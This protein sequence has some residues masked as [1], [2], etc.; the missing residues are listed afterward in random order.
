MK[1]NTATVTVPLLVLC[2]G[3]GLW[4]VS[5]P[6]DVPFERHL[7]DEGANEACA[8]ADVNGDKRSD[9][10][11]GENW[12]E[13]PSWTKHHFRDLPY[14]NN[15]I[16]D[17]SDLPLDVNNDGRIDIVSV[18][19]FSKKI[20]W[21]ENPG[22]G[23]AAW[24]EHAVETDSPVEFAFLVDLDNDGKAREV[25]PQFGDEKKPLAWYEARD[26]AFVKHVV[27]PKSYGHGIGAGDVNKDGR[28]DI[29]TPE[30]WLEAPAD[31]RSG[32]WKMHSGF[33]K[34][35]HYGFLHVLDVNAD[36]RNDIVVSQAHDYGILWFE[37][38]ADGAWN[39]H[40]IDDSWSQG[41]ALTIADLNADGRPDI[42]TGKRYMAHNGRDPGEREP[43]GIYWYEQIPG[44]GNKIEW[45]R[46]V[47]EY[48]GRAGAGMQ[49][50]VADL[51]ADGDPDFVV[52]GK[53]GVFW[54]ENLT[55][56]ATRSK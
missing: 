52:G 45:A 41:H 54:F 32:D 26:G 14:S 3:A 34:G 33:P 16:D 49:I 18:S 27:A 37:Q 55:K 25:L 15:Y 40:I 31:S 35:P 51:D 56:K 38:G 50:N 46:H 24:K 48:G 4:A 2:A 36:G 12:Y 47:I 22:K 23:G 17:F 20:A 29:L 44:A 6:A 10:V 5:R 11:S 13:A 42:L 7:L 39:K 28:A 43:L 1:L 8:V 19:W 9:I 21:W 53:S 30:G